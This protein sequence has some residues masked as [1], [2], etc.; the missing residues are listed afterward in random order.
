MPFSIFARTA[1]A[2]LLF[3]VI[4]FWGGRARAAGDESSPPIITDD[5]VSLTNGHVIKGHVV[6]EVARSYLRMLLDDGKIVT[7][8]WT[9]IDH[10]DLSPAKPAGPVTPWNVPEEAASAAPDDE[11]ETAHVVFDADDDTELEQR[12][13]ND[14]KVW[15]PVCRGKCSIDLFLHVDYRTS[16]G[17]AR[18]ST[19]FRVNAKAGDHVV[20]TPKSHSRAG[21]AIGVSL[22]TVGGVGMLA[23][24]G[25]NGNSD[26]D[27]A[28][29]AWDFMA[30]TSLAF[31]ALGTVLVVTHPKSKVLQ[32]VGNLALGGTAAPTLRRHT[33]LASASSSRAS[34]S[35]RQAPTAQLAPAAR[36]SSLFTIHF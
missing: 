31:T 28:A 14:G 10:V 12:S 23:M 13:R 26:S 9:E 36:T 19:P 32:R 7:I 27:G 30:I 21:F 25:H 34:D 16:G 15:M 18:T 24:A 22:I 6:Y 11:D 8:P 35:W 2:V 4:A 33:E 5:V 1:L 29:M 20:L 17:G 3:V